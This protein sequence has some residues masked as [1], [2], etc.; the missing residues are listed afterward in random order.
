MEKQEKQLTPEQQKRK[1]LL[2]GTERLTSND[3]GKNKDLLKQ[4]QNDVSL[5]EQLAGNHQELINKLVADIHRK[6][7]S[8]YIPGGPARESKPSIPEL[9][10]VQNLKNELVDRFN[11]WLNSQ[12]NLVGKI[13]DEINKLD[14]SGKVMPVFTLYHRHYDKV[15]DFADWVFVEKKAAKDWKPR[16]RKSNN[17]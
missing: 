17:Q 2:K 11:K 8:S 15:R 4:Y 14:Y 10:P 16:K 12:S 5:A 13:T 3:F 9:E 1:R 6:K 7:Y